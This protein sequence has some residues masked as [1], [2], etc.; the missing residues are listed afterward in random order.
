CS[1]SSLPADRLTLNGQRP[2]N[3]FKEDD[4]RPDLSHQ[5]SFIKKKEHS[6]IMQSKLCFPKTVE[7][8]A[9]QNSVSSMQSMQR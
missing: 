9:Y 6:Y 8:A 1:S 2:E 3:R 7:L 4:P 5:F